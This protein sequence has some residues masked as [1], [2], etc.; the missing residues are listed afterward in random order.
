MK[1]KYLKPLAIVLGLFAVTVGCASKKNTSVSDDENIYVVFNESLCYSD[2]QFVESYLRY[3][4]V[5]LDKQIG[6]TSDGK[7]VY[8]IKGENP[9]ELICLRS[10]GDEKVFQNNK[11]IPITD[12][13]ELEFDKMVI[14]GD[15]A[16][17]DQEVIT[18]KALIDKMLSQITDENIVLDEVVGEKFKD[19]SLYSTK[20]KGIC[21]KYNYVVD[22]FGDEYI[23]DPGLNCAWKFTEK[24]FDID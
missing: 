16:I 21:Y 6:V 13:K 24:M 11:V 18:D 12:V 10:E 2:M 3:E 9:D 5:N 19:F 8:S 14:R 1:R 22:E 7:Q 23:Y 15:N 17:E 20:L 4:A